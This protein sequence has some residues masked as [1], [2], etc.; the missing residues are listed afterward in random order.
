M[1]MQEVKDQACW[2]TMLRHGQPKC[3][4][5]AE[6]RMVKHVRVE[7]VRNLEGQQLLYNQVDAGTFDELT[8]AQ[9]ECCDH[10]KKEAA[11]KETF[12]CM[13][14]AELAAC[15]DAAELH[16]KKFTHEDYDDGHFKKFIPA[17]V[18]ESARTICFNKDTVGVMNRPYEQFRFISQKDNLDIAGAIN[19]LTCITEC[20]RNNTKSDFSQS[21]DHSWLVQNIKNLG[22]FKFEL[23]LDTPIKEID[24]TEKKVI[25]GTIV[26]KVNGLGAL[27][28]I[29]WDK[30]CTRIYTKFK[31]GMYADKHIETVLMGAREVL[32]AFQKFQETGTW[33]ADV[34]ERIVALF[35]EHCVAYPAKKDLFAKVGAEALEMNLIA[36][37]D[38][39]DRVPA[40]LADTLETADWRA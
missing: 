21:Q 24:A 28:H 22:A 1:T 7:I 10:W 34:T 20:V 29:D 37:D 27:V 26:K 15:P 8:K 19:D 3:W 40:D 12:K 32:D 38:F 23:L 17:N 9:N 30:G 13:T 6:Q 36:V 5:V 39:A 25:Q 31:L 2:K 14:S 18:T 33:V 11:F 35:K 4:S 16:A